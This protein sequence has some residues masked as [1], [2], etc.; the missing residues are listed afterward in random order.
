MKNGNDAQ[1]PA[2]QPPRLPYHPAVK[3]RFG[4]DRAGWKVLCEAIFPAARTVDAIILALSYCRARGLDVFKR[5]VHIVPMWNSALGRE[6]ETVWP[7]INEIQTSAARTHAWA[8]MDPPQWGPDITRTFRG[9]RRVKSGWEPAEV[10]LTFPEWCAVTVYR[11]IGQQ[12][13]A[14]T[15]PVYWLESY[16]RAGGPGSEL[17]TDVWIRRP[18]GQLHKVAKA[19]SLRAAFPEESDYSAEEMEGKEIDVGGIVVDHAPRVVPPPVPDHVPEAEAQE[20]RSD[21]RVV[22][23]DA[24]PELPAEPEGQPDADAFDSAGWRRDA[25]GAISGCEDASELFEVR[26]KVILPAKGKVAEED[27]RAVAMSYRRAF[28]RLAGER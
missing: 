22:W 13:Y 15:E 18:R 5:P 17:P 28:D 19:A 8:G 27:W 7:S 21:D 9:K 3:E 25:E 6:V 4:V 10:T 24:E 2:L 1:L 11:V 12:R 14:F 23:D 26:E 20:P 16:S